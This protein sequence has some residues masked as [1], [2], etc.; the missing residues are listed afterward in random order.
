MANISAVLRDG[1]GDFF[2]GSICVSVRIADPAPNQALAL[3]NVHQTLNGSIR[4]FAKTGKPE[5]C[6]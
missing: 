6:G 1:C 5:F 3:A 2:I 4:V